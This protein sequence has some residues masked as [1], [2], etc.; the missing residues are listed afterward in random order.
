MN[1]RRN[2]R[3]FSKKVGGTWHI[4]EQNRRY[5]RELN[6]TAGVI[7][8]YTKK[9][10]SEESIVQHL[11]SLYNKPPDECAKDVHE[12]ISEYLKAGLLVRS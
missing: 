4:L 5:V 6:E 2:P 1:I 12:F 10:V 8:E 11:A 3:V 9:P 7:W